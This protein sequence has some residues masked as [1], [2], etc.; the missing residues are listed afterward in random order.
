MKSKVY[1]MANRINWLRTPAE[2][3]GRE[4]HTITVTG[5]NGDRQVNAVIELD[6]VS[7][8]G[9]ELRTDG[10]YKYSVADLINDYQFEITAPNKVECSFGTKLIFKNVYGGEVNGRSWFKAERVALEVDY[11]EIK[12]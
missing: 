7:V 1:E 11:E 10:N 9:A 8:L 2:V 3:L 5:S 6:V 12:L 4:G